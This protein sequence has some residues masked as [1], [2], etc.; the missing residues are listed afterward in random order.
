MQVLVTKADM[1]KWSIE[2]KKS[3]TICLVPTMG[4]FHQGHIS[5][6]KKGKTL[7]DELVVSIFVNPTQF[8][9]NE[10]LDHYPSDIKKDLVLA[11]KIGA[12]A[13]FLPDK[14]DIF[15]KN[16]QTQ[17]T[18]EPLSLYLCGKSRPS[19][20]QGVA[21]IVTKLFNII[22]PDIAV[23]GQKD[24]QQLQIIKQLV[25][26]LDFNIKIVSGRIIR[27]KDGLAMSS[28]NSY[29]SNQ[30]R[31][32][33]LNLFKSLN[34]VK[35]SIKKGE[36][37]IGVIK[38]MLEDFFKPYKELQIEYLCFCNTETLVEVDILDSQVLFAVAAK[39][40]TTRL[41][42]NLIIG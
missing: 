7:A 5:L 19:H 15:E 35:N 33:A 38:A 20:F 10:D 24:F 30:Q 1:K 18:L 34:L 41:I 13:V 25:K 29:L 27:E 2:K 23:F 14:K 16:F 3:K 12:S 36:K 32:I 8:G 21:T 17:I 6:M 9:H 4:Y 40:G 42:D 39:I 31:K 22:A 11:K 28:R 37:N 26:D